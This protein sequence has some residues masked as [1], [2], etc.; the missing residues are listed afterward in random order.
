MVSGSV[1][2]TWIPHLTSSV[3]LTISLAWDIFGITRQSDSWFPLWG[4]VKG[5]YCKKDS[6]ERKLLFKRRWWEKKGGGG[7]QLFSSLQLEASDPCAW[8]SVRNKPDREE[9][10][11]G[12]GVHAIP[13]CVRDLFQGKWTELKGQRKMSE[14]RLEK[15]WGEL[16]WGAS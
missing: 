11:R 10:K 4:S 15:V 16:R 9:L 7:E 6:F 1:C 2:E 5:N 3:G 14:T 8:I 13:M 12:G